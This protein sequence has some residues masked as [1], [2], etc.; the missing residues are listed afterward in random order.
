[1]MKALTKFSK[2]ECKI[3]H[4]NTG[5]HVDTDVIENDCVMRIWDTSVD[6]DHGD[7]DDNDHEIWC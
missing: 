5:C 3:R 7:S 6:D 2:V 4:K 1:M